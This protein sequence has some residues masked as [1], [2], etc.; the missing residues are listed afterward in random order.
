LKDVRL[1]WAGLAMVYK[2]G[3]EVWNWSWESEKGT[4][5]RTAGLES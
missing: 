4:M 5:K 1:S 2:W 3:K